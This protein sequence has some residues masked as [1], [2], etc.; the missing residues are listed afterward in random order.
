MRFGVF[1]GTF[2]PPH[3]G[4]LIL[5]MEC[6]WQLRLDRVYWVL[7]PQPP[8]KPDQRISEIDV[9]I[10]MVA[11][12]IYTNP[13]FELSLIDIRRPAPHYAVDTMKLLRLQ[14]PDD[15]LV[16]LMGGDSLNELATWHT[17][18]DFIHAC[19]QLG[20]MARSESQVNIKN[21]HKLF[22]ELM[23]K[24][25]IIETP[26]IDISSSVIRARIINNVPYRYFVPDA[27]NKIIQA[28]NLYR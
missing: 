6:T 8:H 21:A 18:T 26:L 2:D 9:R 25:N 4:H 16:Y 3:L 23:E 28:N 11:A 27:V 19:D 20:V 24:L 22:P 12:A 10:Q 1:G 7:T 15:E 5:A 17:P 14:H 13:S